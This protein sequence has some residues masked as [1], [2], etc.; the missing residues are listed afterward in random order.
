MTVVFI[1]FY[2][3]AAIVD[4]SSSL[5]KKRELL[6]LSCFVLVLLAGFRNPF[7]W[8]D[9]AGYMFAFQQ[10][11]NDLFTFSFNDKPFGYT[12]F[13]FYFLG[14][15]VKTFSDNYTVYFLFVAG[16]TWLLY[17][18][19]YKKYC[20]LPLMGITVYVARFYLGRD[21]MQIRECLAIPI[22]L[23]AS[24]YLIERKFWMFI[25]F[26]AIAYQ[27]HHSALFGV[28]LYFLYW[29]HF[30]QKHIY[31]G[32]AIAYLI[33]VFL[34]PNIKEYV[35]SSD[36]FNNM[37]YSYVREGSE[38]AFAAGI[39]NPMIYYQSFLLLTFT[40]FEKR[41]KSIPD[42][43]FLRTAYF[44]STIVL[45]ILCDFAVLS[46]RLSTIY[47]TIETIIIPSIIWVFDKKERLFPTIIIG[48]V[49]STFF[50][51]NYNPHF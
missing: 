16:L 4:Q 46:A 10:K 41:F 14:V 19:Y 30:K 9:A 48:A 8:S 13:G 50:Y 35:Q 43:Y 7:A 42:Y 45:I 2:I 51:L 26:I 25:L 6:A 49:L 39:G 47:A 5:H 44:Y 11:T 32:L 1:L 21:F 33:A 27:F 12:E 37:A 23:L 31:W 36:F 18:R 28:P 34:G 22:V 38:K 17:F 29:F 3:F 20:L 24:K 15:I 40:F